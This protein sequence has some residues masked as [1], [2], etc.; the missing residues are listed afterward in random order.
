MSR[1][2]RPVRAF[3]SDFEK[4]SW[5]SIHHYV[6]ESLAYVVAANMDSGAEDYHLETAVSKI[7]ASESAWKVVD[8]AIQVRL[9][10]SVGMHY[11]LKK[12]SKLKMRI[13][14]LTDIY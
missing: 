3:S 8:D 12:I 10:Y 6:T 9:A 7:F 14:K 4:L 13:K 11:V 1:P 5:M 2:G